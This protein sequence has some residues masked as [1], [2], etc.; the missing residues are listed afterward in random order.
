MRLVAGVITFTATAG[1][2]AGQANYRATCAAPGPANQPHHAL[3]SCPDSPVPGMRPANMQCAVLAHAHF[4]QLPSGDL[5]LR[6]ESFGALE[7]AQSASTP[8]SV[9]V[10]AVGK[11]WLLTISRKGERSPGGTLAAEIGPIPPF[12]P[13]TSYTLDVAEAAFDDDM[14]PVVIPCRTLSPRP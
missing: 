5:Y 13:A 9:V 3:V 1:C 11:D 14:R 2:L 12:A 10:Q 7:A 8:L 6:I 4:S